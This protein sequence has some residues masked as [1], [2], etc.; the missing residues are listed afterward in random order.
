MLQ[1]FLH[2]GN[3]GD[4]WHT[5]WERGRITRDMLATMDHP[6]TGLQRSTTSAVLCRR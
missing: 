6:V 3:D 2:S 1:A 4:M 5:L